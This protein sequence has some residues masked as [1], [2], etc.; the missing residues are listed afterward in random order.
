MKEGWKKGKIRNMGRKKEEKEKK[1]GMKVGK[2]N[3]KKG[4]NRER[5]K[6]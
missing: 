2:M 5:K 6:E 4:M 3:R 1:E